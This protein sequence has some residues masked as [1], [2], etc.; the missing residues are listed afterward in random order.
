MGRGDV[1]APGKRAAGAKLIWSL[2]DNGCE[3]C[4]N[5]QK[6]FF[7]VFP[8]SRCLI[9]YNAR[10]SFP[11]AKQNRCFA[12]FLMVKFTPVGP[13]HAYR[14]TLCVEIFLFVN[15]KKVK[16]VGVHI[17]KGKR[18]TYLLTAFFRLKSNTSIWLVARSQRDLELLSLQGVCNNRRCRSRRYNSIMR[19]RFFFR[20]FFHQALFLYQAIGRCVIYCRSEQQRQ[21]VRRAVGGAAHVTRPASE[22][23]DNSLMREIAGGQHRARRP[24]RSEIARKIDYLIG[25]TQFCPRAPTFQ[26][27]APACI[28]CTRNFLPPA[29]NALHF[30]RSRGCRARGSWRSKPITLE[31]LINECLIN[32]MFA[33]HFTQIG[34]GIMSSSAL[35]LP[36]AA[37]VC[38]CVCVCETMKV[39]MCVCVADAVGIVLH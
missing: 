7:F 32:Q 17:V 26:Y 12:L 9:V 18:I 28:Q 37:D 19:C 3:E 35:T 31:L 30:I 14:H 16:A 11:S 36:G 38:G 24:P 8:L 22:A 29:S 4:E 2:L 21:H 5:V 15:I 13:N 33:K 20:A 34:C 23:A 39:C 6:L 27:T 25:N 10:H 1:K